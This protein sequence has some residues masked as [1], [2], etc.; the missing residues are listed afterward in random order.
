MPRPTNHDAPGGGSSNPERVGVRKTPAGGIGHR[1]RAAPSAGVPSVSNKTPAAAS[2]A[3][4]A[5]VGS[6]AGPPERKVPRIPATGRP[7]PR[8]RDGGPG[9]EADSPAAG[10]PDPRVAEQRARTSLRSAHR[11]LPAA[12]IILSNH[13]MPARRSGFFSSLLKG[14]ASAAKTTKTFRSTTNRS[15]INTFLIILSIYVSK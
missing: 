7:A 8:R 10:L 6:R 14:F 12:D 2:P 9:A 13:V 1:S 4:A 11:H 3:A 15:L 5:P